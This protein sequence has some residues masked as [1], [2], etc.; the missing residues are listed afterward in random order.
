[1][2]EY[3]LQTQIKASETQRMVNEAARDFA[4]QYIKPNIIQWDEAQFFPK[5]M[6]TT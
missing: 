2:I 6:K 4:V 3:E 1:M 5:E